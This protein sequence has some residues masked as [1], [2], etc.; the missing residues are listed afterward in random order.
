SASSWD[1]SRS[2]SLTSAITAFLANPR[3]MA[4][5]RSPAVDPVGSSRLD[6]SGSVTAIWSG[7]RW[8][9]ATTPE[10]DEG[11]S[12]GG[13][14]RSPERDQ[15]GE[16]PAEAGGEHDPEPVAAGDGLEQVER[17]VEGPAA[18]AHDAEGD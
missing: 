6:P 11:R 9:V 14:R 17:L 8:R 4:R 15:Q 5:A 18:R 13:G 1:R 7:I 2:T 12:V 10:P 16:R 3:A